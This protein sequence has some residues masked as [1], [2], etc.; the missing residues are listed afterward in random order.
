VRADRRTTLIE[1]L[2]RFIGQRPAAAPQFAGV[3]EAGGPAALAPLAGYRVASVS[4]GGKLS[5]CRLFSTLR[6]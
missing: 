1:R 5:G 6:M 2:L 3:T 4:Y